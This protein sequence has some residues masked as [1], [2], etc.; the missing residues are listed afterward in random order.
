MCLRRK[1]CL[2]SI[3]VPVYNVEKYLERCITSIV[4][5]DM[6]N[7]EIILVDDGS[8]DMSGLIC[9]RLASEYPDTINVIHKKNG[10]LSSARNT[11]IYNAC[12]RYIFF[13]DSDDSVV[14]NFIEKIKKRLE[15]DKY[16]IIEF[17]ACWEREFGKANPICNEN[18]KL[19]TAKEE[20]CKILMNK[21]GNEICFKIYRKE[22]F[23]NIIFPVGK[24]YEDIAV[25]YKLLMKAEKILNI[26]SEYYIYNITN[27]NSITKNSSIKNLQD[28][29]DSVN[30]LCYG[31]EQFC[32]NNGIEKLY[33]EYYKRHVYIYIY[34]KLLKKEQETDLQRNIKNYL[35]ENNSYNIIKYRHYDMKRWIMFELLVLLRR[36]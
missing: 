2:L 23:D 36:V 16:D 13:L 26:D 33:I 3:V 21:K 34:L 20:I 7:I 11:G 5:Q 4:K 22:L 9:D 17:K 28:M 25:T 6:S 12:G 1:K 32:N 27:M 30:S 15:I 18:E 19:V 8:S 29:Y 10:G 35:L 24:A 31:V 14:D